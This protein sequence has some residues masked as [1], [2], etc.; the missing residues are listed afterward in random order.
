[1]R[2]VPYLQSAELQSWPIFVFTCTSWEQL[3][4][5]VVLLPFPCF[6]LSL[7]QSYFRRH[8]A[9]ELAASPHLAQLR[10]LNLFD[11]NIGD[12]GAEAIAASSYLAESTR[13]LWRRF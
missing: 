11:N 3:E 8:R 13:R 1:E 10:E 4:R 9:T 5:R 12:E 6:A 2:W 7:D